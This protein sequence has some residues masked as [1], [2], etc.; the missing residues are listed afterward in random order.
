MMGNVAEIPQT[1]EPGSKA[2]AF[3]DA[4]WGPTGC[5]PHMDEGGHDPSCG[6]C[7]IGWNNLYQHLVQVVLN[8]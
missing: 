7:L 6:P 8:N 3:G 4:I 5:G 1:P 2:L